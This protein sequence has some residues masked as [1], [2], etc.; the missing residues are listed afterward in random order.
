MK[1]GSRFNL[2]RFDRDMAFSSMP[3]SRAMRDEFADDALAF[4]DSGYL[5]KSGDGAPSTIICTFS[6]PSKAFPE[7][8]PAGSAF[9]FAMGDASRDAFFLDMTQ[10][11]QAL[12][13]VFVSQA[14]S[15]G[16]VGETSLLD[17]MAGLV[18]IDPLQSHPFLQLQF[19]GADE[20]AFFIPGLFDTLI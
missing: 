6:D 1:W 10:M 5:K 7:A 15:G 20:D 8:A 19:P 14:E 18:A 12:D 16:M 9:E 2:G 3:F 13:D 17:P 4:A 11:R